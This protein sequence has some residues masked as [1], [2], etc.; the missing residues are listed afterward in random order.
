VRRQLSPYPASCAR[1]SH[2]SNDWREMRKVDFSGSKTLPTSIGKWQKA[3]AGI[4]IGDSTV[5]VAG[6]VGKLHSCRP[7]TAREP[8]SV[9]AGTHGEVLA[10]APRMP[11][12]RRLGS[13]PASRTKAQASH[14]GARRQKDAT[15]ESDDAICGYELI[16]VTGA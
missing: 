15:P 12:T 14:V 8:R 9:P 2:C 1:L 4:S 3:S 11:M 5:S 7:Y 10:N 13:R 16:Y 6:P